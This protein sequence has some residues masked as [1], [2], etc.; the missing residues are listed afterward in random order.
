MPSTRPSP[1]KAFLPII[2]AVAIILAA[3][4]SVT[5]AFFVGVFVLARWAWG[6]R[7]K[8]KQQQ[9][10]RSKGSINHCNHCG[11][12]NSSEF[13]F[14]VVCGSD[15]IISG[16]APQ[17][18]GR[19]RNKQRQSDRLREPVERKHK[20]EHSPAWNRADKTASRFF[21][22]IL[23]FRDGKYY[24]GHT[25]ELRERLQEHRDGGTKSTAGRDPKL[26]WFITVTSRN[27][28]TEQ[29]A[30]LKNLIDKNPRQVG[31]MVLDFK[32]LNSELDYS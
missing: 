28:A 14:C 24:A 16:D 6:K 17:S 3:A 20:R 2:V 22:Y 5:L 7:N 12:Q 25:R 11:A 9:L 30:K 29:E 18:A 8:E 23:K 32:D 27:E 4:A 31:R 15:K 13:R 26:V 21:V 10:E 1:V 19:W